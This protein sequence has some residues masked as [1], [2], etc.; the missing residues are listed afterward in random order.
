MGFGV[1]VEN[2]NFFRLTDNLNV[3]NFQSFFLVFTSSLLGLTRCLFSLQPV[4]RTITV[5]LSFHPPQ[6]N[7]NKENTHHEKV[8]PKLANHYCLLIEKH[9]ENLEFGWVCF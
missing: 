2:F 8:I 7:S 5:S 1:L 4:N 9:Y 6:E 3:I